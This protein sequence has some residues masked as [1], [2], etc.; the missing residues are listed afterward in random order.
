MAKTSGAVFNFDHIA[1]MINSISDICYQEYGLE[2]TKEARVEIVEQVLTHYYDHIVTY[3]V[4]VTGSDPYKF[5]AWSGVLIY[6]NL[7]TSDREAAIK[8]LSAAIA[9]L[10]RALLES[11]K[12]VPDWYLRKALSMV[13]NEF[14][15]QA[16]LGLGKNGLYMAF[17]GA[18]LV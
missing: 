10:N 15:S 14:A 13:I 1:S 17:K 3:N 6:E 12:T 9:A 4:C 7:H 8:F 2:L 18:S 16:H 5:L 11:G